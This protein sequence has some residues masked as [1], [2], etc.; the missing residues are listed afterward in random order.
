[1]SLERYFSLAK[2]AWSVLRS[3]SANQLG[4]VTA[5]K[6][7]HLMLSWKCNL[8]CIMCSVWKKERFKQARTSDFLRL[9]D[10]LP[11]L[12]IVKISGGE[13]FLRT[14]CAEIVSHLQKRHNPYCLTII[15]NGTMTERM[16][17]FAKRCG[18]PGLHLRLS[19]EGRG[20]IHDKLRGCPGCF[21]KTMTTLEALLPIMRQRRFTIGVNYNVNNETIKDL[22]WILDICRREKL[23]FIP[24]FW[25]APFLEPGRPE[26]SRALIDDLVDFRHRLESIY[27]QEEGFSFLEA[28]LLKRTVLGLYDQALESCDYKRFACRANRNTIYIMPDGSLVTCGIRQEVLGNLMF[29]NFAD[30]WQSEKVCQ[31]RKI[32]DSCSG[33]CQYSLKIM[34]K[35]YNGEIFGL[36][37]PY[38]WRKQEANCNYRRE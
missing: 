30:V 32:A 1:M 6:M 14:D 8:K 9:I 20:A 26:D 25:V 3:V 27:L 5:P 16:V 38:E 12:D 24:G 28:L 18:R 33:C 19:L 7:A 15:S 11:S 2:M 17:E 29:Q 21:D 34:S 37:A 4:L 10:N 36:P 13:P 31:A 35:L 22:P 23:N